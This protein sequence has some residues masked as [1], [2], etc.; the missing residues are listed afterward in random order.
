M[1][2]PA[3]E[4][5]AGKLAYSAYYLH[6]TDSS[7][8]LYAPK[9]SRQTHYVYIDKRK[10]RIR[11]SNVKYPRPSVVK[12]SS[13]ERHDSTCKFE[14]QLQRSNLESHE[15]VKRFQKV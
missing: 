13:E 2:G 7:P 3:L 11:K 4:A 12:G 8:S 14:K 1:R 9:P 10:E 15:L 6:F 5:Y